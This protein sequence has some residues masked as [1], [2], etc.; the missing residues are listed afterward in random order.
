MSMESVKI[1]SVELQ[2][3]MKFIFLPKKNPQ[4]DEMT[5][6]KQYA[7]IQHRDFETSY[8]T[9]LRGVPTVSIQEIGDHALKLILASQ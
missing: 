3:I 1:S 5:M 8:S 6:K 9:K 7:N 2:V 4:V